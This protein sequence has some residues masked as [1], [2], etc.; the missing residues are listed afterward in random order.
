MADRT[1]ERY[2]TKGVPGRR[3]D[4]IPGTRKRVTGTQ[5]KSR[6]HGME[7]NPDVC[8]GNIFDVIGPKLKGYCELV[9]VSDGTARGGF[10]DERRDG[11][12]GNINLEVVQSYTQSGY[13]SVATA[14]VKYDSAVSE[15][16]LKVV[17]RALASSKLE[18]I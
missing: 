8:G 16:D 10:P 3:D 1:V 18:K 6:E 17:R 4:L 5:L 11:E 7:L 12:F 2:S 15:S 14:Q 9:S 13:A